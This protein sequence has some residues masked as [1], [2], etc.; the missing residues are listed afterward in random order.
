MARS[1]NSIIELRADGNDTNGGGFVAGAS[2]TD[3]SQQAA[4]Q[5][6]VTDG[7]TNGTTTITSATANFGVD[8]VGNWIYVAGGTG[9]VVADWYEITSRT[10]STTIVVD[11]STGLTAGTAVTLKIGGA[12]LSPGLASL[13]FNSSSAGCD[14]Y[15]KAGTYT[16]SSTSANVV[17]GTV[18][19]TAAGSTTNAR[20]W[21]GYNTTRTRNNTD[22]SRPLI[23]VPAAGVSSVTVFATSNGDII[24]RNVNV[25][26]ASKTSIRGFSCSDRTRFRHCKATGCTNT[27]F[28]ISS[29]RAELCESSGHSSQPAFIINGVFGAY[30]CEARD[31]TALGFQIG[32]GGCP[33]FRC[34]AYDNSGATTDGFDLQSNLTPSTLYYCEARGNG[35]HG[36]NMSANFLNLVLLDH[37]FAAGHTAGSAEGFATNGVKD[38]IYL[39]SCGGYNNTSNYN[40]SNL[41][42]VTNFQAC[43][44]DPYVTADAGDMSKNATANGGALL[45]GVSVASPRGATTSYEDIGFAQHQDS[46]GGGTTVIVVEDD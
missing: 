39:D 1:G 15:H 12:L 2:G 34:A 38:G 5:Y 45:R 4:A 31:G 11:R 10:N 18:S 28:N 21:V 35:R 25:D 16:L 46:G 20:F 29:G 22:A 8:V 27:S 17:G 13:L 40:T 14:V 32:G 37:C 36:F 26:G 41:L 33:L 23:Q 19:L 7:V 3:W 43:S 30:R 6:S 24:V 9:S 42:N 44:V